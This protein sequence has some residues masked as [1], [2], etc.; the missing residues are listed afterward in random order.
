M[1]T[2]LTIGFFDGVHLG[3]IHLLKEL[4]KNPHTTIVTF[5]NHPLSFLHP[6]APP[7]LISQEERL[8]LLKPYAD[9]L[10]VLPFD[11][12]LAATSFEELL[13]RFDL[14]QILLGAG[15]RFGYQKKGTEEAVRAWAL[16]RNITVTY[17]PKLLLNGDPISSSRIRQALQTGN[18]PLAQTLLGRTP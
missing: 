2:A 1:K 17:L 11:A 16:P 15:S 12:Q 4:R 3:H 7:L 8:R 6:P 14:S 9:T 18:K 13:S 10:L 5:S